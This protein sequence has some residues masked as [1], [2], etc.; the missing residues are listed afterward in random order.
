MENCKNNFNSLEKRI[1]CYQ[2]NIQKPIKKW[3]KN[4]SDKL[5]D[6]NEDCASIISISESFFKKIKRKYLNLK[7]KERNADMLLGIPKDRF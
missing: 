2:E 1:N 4:F 3:C 7:D 6:L 5:D